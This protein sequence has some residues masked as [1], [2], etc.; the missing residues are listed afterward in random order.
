MN[1]CLGGAWAG[2]FAVVLPLLA[3]DIPWNAGLMRPVTILA[4]GGSIC[5]ASLP[6]PVSKGGT[7]TMWSIRNAAM[8]AI[9]KMLGCSDDYWQEAMGIWEGAVPLPVLSGKN[10]FGDSFGFLI[11]DGSAGGCGAKA[12]GDGVDSA[13]NQVTSTLSIPN[14]ETHEANN[15]VLFL[16]RRQVKD[17][18][19]AG[20][21]RGGAGIEEMLMVYDTDRVHATL[22]MNGLEVPNAEGIFGGLPGSCNYWGMVRDSSV[23]ENLRGGVI[24]QTIEE[25]GRQVEDLPGG[26]PSMELSQADLFYFRCTGGGGYG[27]P[28][29]RTPDAVLADVLNGLISVDQAY[30]VFGVVVDGKGDRL[31][32][33]DTKTR[34]QSILKERLKLV[35]HQE[36][37][38][39]VDGARRVRRRGEYLEI[40]EASGEKFIRCTRCGVYI[41]PADQNPK[42]WAIQ[43][44]FPLQKAGP[45]F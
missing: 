36:P 18:P 5:N 13:G 6:A 17:S 11:M 4:P 8:L 21:Y 25:F 14:I 37:V 10:Q 44:K 27:D 22:T 40:A 3:Y 45:L 38:R 39:R 1:C 19:G 43:G 35:T 15:P 30:Q 26:V 41:C 12:V 34:R 16:F 7:G 28:L 31:N 20:K 42:A 2:V 23:L 32:M 24:P 29:D 33:E 9:S